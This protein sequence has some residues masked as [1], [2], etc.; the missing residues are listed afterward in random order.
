MND[1]SPEME[2]KYRSALLER[3]GAERLKMGC[4]MFATARALAAA[5]ILEREPSASPARM[6]EEL[7][8][9]FYGADFSADAQERIAARLRGTAEEPSGSEPPRRVPVDWD[10]LEM[11]LTTN[12]DEFSCYLDL[13]SGTIQMLPVDRFGADDAWPAEDEI[14]A[15]LTAGHLIDVEPL[16]SSVEY[17]WMAE[18]ASS[19]C[20][21]RLRNELDVALDGRG[22]FRRFKRVLSGHPAERERWFGFRDQRLHETA[23]EWLADHGIEPTTIPPRQGS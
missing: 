13:R 4:S 17:S 18:F 6:R 10:D 11:A 15:G 7:F 23:R 14:D 16:E 1:T 12:A 5:S 20:H 19:V 3:S 8:L 22:A 21:P 2:R 9:R